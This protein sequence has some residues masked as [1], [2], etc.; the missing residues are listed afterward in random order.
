MHNVNGNRY[1][2]PNPLSHILPDAKASG[3]SPLSKEFIMSKSPK[4]V[5]AKI[6]KEAKQWNKEVGSEMQTKY[7]ELIQ[8]LNRLKESGYQNKYAQIIAEI[9]KGEEKPAFKKATAN[10]IVSWYIKVYDP[11]NNLKPSGAEGT[12]DAQIAGG[13]EA[14]DP[15]KE[16]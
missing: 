4:E 15:D 9:E 2:A 11:A 13:V 3:S 6:L 5:A 12:P 7:L 1:Q 14:N 10:L 8:N 16:S